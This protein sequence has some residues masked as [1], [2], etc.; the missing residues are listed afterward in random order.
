MILS[1]LRALGVPSALNFIQASFLFRRNVF[2]RSGVSLRDEYVRS[3]FI[4]WNIML[5]KLDGECA[6]VRYFADF[7]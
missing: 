6:T 5:C 3:A 1:K 7:A 2:V 4:F